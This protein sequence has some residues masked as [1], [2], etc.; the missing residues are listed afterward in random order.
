MIDLES[1]VSAVQTSVHAA[2]Q[3][4]QQRNQS[5]IGDFFDQRQVPDDRHV[6][7]GESESGE[8]PT[9]TVYQPK[10]VTM[11]YPQETAKGIETTPVEVPLLT[12]VPITSSRIK[13]LRFKTHL[14]VSLN[15]RNEMEIAFPSRDSGGLFKS[16]KGT[17]THIAELEIVLGDDSSPSG[18]KMMVEGYERALRAQ[19]PG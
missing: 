9:R 17:K 14:E 12:L 5:V 1:L 18:L 7:S 4:L 8:P 16:D 15:D 13:E 6:D 11:L 3:S 10:L 2:N 19:I